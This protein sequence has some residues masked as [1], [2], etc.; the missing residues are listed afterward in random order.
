MGNGY[1]LN[2]ENVCCDG[3]NSRGSVLLWLIVTM[4]ISAVLASAVLYLTT[5]FTFGELLANSQ[6]RTYYLAESGGYYAIPQIK[7]DHASATINLNGKTYTLSNG[8]K[9]SL[10]VDDTYTSYTLLESTGIINEGGWSESRRKITYR[11]YKSIDISFSSSGDLDQN[12]SIVVGGASVVSTGPSGGEPALN[13]TGESALISLK[14]DGNPDLPDLSAQWANF[15]GLL[16]YALQI[17]ANA[18]VQGSKGEHFI[19]GVSFRLDTNDTA[20]TSDDRFYGISFF[21]SIGRGDVQKPAWVN[22]LDANFDAIMNGN[23]YL[24]LWRKISS[25]SSYILMDYKLLTIADGVVDNG[26]LKA[27][28]T[29]VVDVQERYQ[30]DGSGQYILDGLGNRIRENLITGYVQGTGVYSRNTINWDFSNFNLVVWGWKIP[31]Q[32]VIAPQTVVDGTLTTVNFDTRRPEEAGI[33]GYYD[34]PAA[35]DQFLDDFSFTLRTTGGSGGGGGGG[36]Q[37]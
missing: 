36:I 25:G 29:L 37:Y 11:V 3:M 21:R 28:S 33:H 26:E 2:N 10:S 5:G 8:D 13:L 22:N 4:T 1:T 30:T 18:D 12:F 32:S 35:N 15:D 27:W 23:V 20:G 24:I 7:A 14:W 9:F 16:N 31:G 17:K 6:M 34:S 19:L